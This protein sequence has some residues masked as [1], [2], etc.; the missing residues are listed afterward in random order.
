[1]NVPLSSRW[2]GRIS[3]D[4]GLELQESLVA[5]KIAGDPADHLLLL[6]H[7][8]VYTMGRS[9]DESS[10]GEETRLPHPVRRTNRGGQATYHGP[11]QLVAY[12]ILDLGTRGRDLHAYLRFLEEVI[13]GVLGTWS[14]QA[15]RRDGLTGVWVGERKIA[16]IG[17][18][19]RRW[20]SMHGFALN[21]AEDLPA[22]GAITP[23]GI[24]GVAMTSLAEECGDHPSVREV[25]EVTSSVFLDQLRSLP[26]GTFPQP[27]IPS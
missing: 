24:T 5:G 20:I 11:G 8:P 21:I 10:L 23:C 15:V 27:G 19:V 16:S 18:G 17:V 25:A 9:R 26:E 14:V 12:P 7:D 6:E 3:Y 22:F 1:M 13:I 4:V 2:L